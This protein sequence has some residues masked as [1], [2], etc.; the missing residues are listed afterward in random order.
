MSNHINQI[1]IEKPNSLPLPTL[2]NILIDRYNQR[3]KRIW[4]DPNPYVKNPLWEKSEI[5][6]KIKELK[7]ITTKNN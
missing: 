3:L 7:R 2:E 4:V 1:P 5:E 6:Q